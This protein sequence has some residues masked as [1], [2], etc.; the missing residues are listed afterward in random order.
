V[1]T[2][3][4][5]PTVLDAAGIQLPEHLDGVPLRERTSSD[6][7]LIQVSESEVG[8]ALRTNRWKYYVHAPE[9]GDVPGADRYAER[10]LYDLDADPYEL[11]NLIDSANHQEIAAELRTALIAEISRIERQTV[12]I[13]P[14]PTPRDRG[15]FPETTVRRLK[16]DGRRLE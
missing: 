3:D 16:L 7:V 11:D 5:V 9:A 14:W 1:S 6:G 2:V 10:A 15:R 8:R 13:T 12:T 4:V